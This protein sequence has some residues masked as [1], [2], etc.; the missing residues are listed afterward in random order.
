MSNR[1]I[2]ERLTLLAAMWL[3][4]GRPVVAAAFL[5]FA[6]HVLRQKGGDGK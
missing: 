6:A 1:A 4:R 2:V 3:E 5:E